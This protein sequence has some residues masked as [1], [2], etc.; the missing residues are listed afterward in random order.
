MAKKRRRKLFGAALASWRKAHRKPSKK[1]RKSRRKNPHSC[2]PWANPKR[3]TSRRR[4]KSYSRARRYSRRRRSNPLRL[5]S[6]PSFRGIAKD[7]QSGLLAAVAISGALVATVW[8]TR[9]LESRVQAVSSGA[10]N[11]LMK[12]AV[13]TAVSMAAARVLRGNQQMKIAATGAA[14]LPLLG[15]GVGR[16]VPQLTG[17]VPAIAMAPGA[18]APAAPARL[19]MYPGARLSDSMLNAELEAELDADSEMGTY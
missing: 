5:P 11:L 14:F 2:A 7:T 15:E 6:I 8:A 12:I 10:P 4:R 16:F 13:A 1:R 18:S 17:F 19:G 3:R 9:Q